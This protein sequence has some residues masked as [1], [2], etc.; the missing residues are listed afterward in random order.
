MDLYFYKYSKEKW[1][2]ELEYILV[3]EANW[4]EKYAF[5]ILNLSCS[6]DKRYVF[7]EE[8]V[9][10]CNEKRI[11]I[12]VEKKKVHKGLPLVKITFYLFL[13]FVFFYLF[14]VKKKKEEKKN[15][16]W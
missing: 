10:S 12:P 13:F 7:F 5:A 6:F 15:I 11:S 14:C 3:Y 9:I 4:A 8:K 2:Y 16:L 1:S